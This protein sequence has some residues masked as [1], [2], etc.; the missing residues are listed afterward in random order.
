[1]A[2]HGERAGQRDL[3]RALSV[4][5]QEFDIAHLDRPQPADRA[6]DPRHD[7]RAARAPLHGRGVVEVDT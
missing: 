4:G 7:N 3:D 6:D 5:A 2:R 1:L